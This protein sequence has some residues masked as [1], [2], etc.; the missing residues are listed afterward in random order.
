MYLRFKCAGMSLGG[1]IANLTDEYG[2]NVVDNGTVKATVNCHVLPQECLTLIE[3][4]CTSRRTREIRNDY[5]WI[6]KNEVLLR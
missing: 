2:S 1:I 4:R 5:A 6:S 3:N